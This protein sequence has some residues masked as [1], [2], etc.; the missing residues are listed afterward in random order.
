MIDE[1]QE[2]PIVIEAEQYHEGMEDGFDDFRTPYIHTEEGNML[3]R[4]GD[5]IITGIHGERY[6]C[7][8]SIFHRAYEPVEDAE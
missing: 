2:K 6:P 4:E 7:L 3:I 1:I 5:Y 8:P